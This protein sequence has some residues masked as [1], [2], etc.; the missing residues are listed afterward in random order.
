MG[1]GEAMERGERELDQR[2]LVAIVTGLAI[3]PVNPTSTL[4]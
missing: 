2:T 3:V 4:R 1:E